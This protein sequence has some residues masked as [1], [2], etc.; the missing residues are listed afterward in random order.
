VELA[1]V[2]KELGWVF[3]QPQWDRPHLSV[4][5]GPNGLATMTCFYD[6]A[7]IPD[8]L[9]SDI[10]LLG[11]DLFGSYFNKMKMIPSSYITEVFK[12]APSRGL[13]RKLSVINDPEGKARII[14]ILDY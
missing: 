2:V 7:E 14:A 8:G 6:I 13:I 12:L 1:S 3:D 5:A 10:K 9:E 4:K 11:G